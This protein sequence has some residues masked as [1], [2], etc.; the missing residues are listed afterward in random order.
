MIKNILIVLSYPPDSTLICGMLNEPMERTVTVSEEHFD[1][2]SKIRSNHYDLIVVGQLFLEHVNSEGKGALAEFLGLCSDTCPVVGIYRAAEWA[3]TMEE[4]GAILTIEMSSAR[5]LDLSTFEQRL[6][7]SLARNAQCR[8]SNKQ[9]DILKIEISRLSE[10]SSRN[11]RKNIAV[12]KSIRS[13]P[14][15][16]PIY[17]YIDEA[18]RSAQ[19]G[20]LNWNMLKMLTAVLSILIVFLFWMDF[21]QNKEIASIKQLDNSVSSSCE[22]SRCATRQ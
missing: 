19:K 22:A 21:I 9:L 15:N 7:V 1:A 20:Q 12:L 16:Y 8:I 5:P 13:D 6:K 11:I 17:S 14:V 10:D 4:L 18:I 2:V 3:V